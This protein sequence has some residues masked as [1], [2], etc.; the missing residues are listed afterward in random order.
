[1]MRAVIVGFLVVGPSGLS[2]LG[3]STAVPTRAQPGSPAATTSVD[4]HGEP[5][6]A[7]LRSI[8]PPPAAPDLELYDDDGY[9]FGVKTGS[10]P[11]PPPPLA[12]DSNLLPETQALVATLQDAT[13]FALVGV[14]I[15]GSTSP[16]K[17]LS[18]QLSHQPDAIAAFDWLANQFKP[19]P[20]LYA[21]WALRTLAPDHARAHLEVLN[22]DRRRVWSAHGCH[23]GPQRVRDLVGEIE[24]LAM[25]AP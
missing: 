10:K 14:G 21:Y 7:G 12:M 19:V 24:Y 9:L 22:H 6:R 2:C 13:M 4:A 17:Q 8:P 23:L 1:M 25:P 5:Q 15:V 20:R 11:A 3:R 16:G 18:L